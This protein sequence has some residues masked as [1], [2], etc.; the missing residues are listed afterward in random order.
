V[1]FL[2]KED[3]GQRG[4]KRQNSQLREILFWAQIAKAAVA[5]F[6]WEL[7]MQMRRLKKFASIRQPTSSE[8]GS[9]IG[10]GR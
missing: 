10:R 9:A 1:D 5:A 4:P 2:K 8:H 3:T 7:M 6:V